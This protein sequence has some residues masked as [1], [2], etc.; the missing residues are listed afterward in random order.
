MRAVRCLSNVNLSGRAVLDL[1][2]TFETKIRITLNQHFP[3]HR[4]MRGMAYGASFTEGFMLENKRPRLF[5]MTLRAI[6]VETGHCQ[7]ACRFENVRTVWIMT[8]HAI[9]PP[10][11][12]G[13]VLGQIE[14]GMRLQ[15]AIETRRRVLSRID[16]ELASSPAHCNM[17]AA[18]S[19][20]G[21][22]PGSIRKF[23]VVKIQT[24]V[25]TSRK[26]ARD[27]GVAI[28]AGCISHISGAGHLNWHE[29]RLS[30]GRAGNDQRAHENDAGKDSDQGQ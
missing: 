28:I 12:Y 30:Q 29:N 9:H 6:L 22:A 10:L 3:I 19:V 26:V 13:M 27:I 1:S 23:G 7:S 8:L 21:F 17:L 14:F 25:S 16:D 4:A 2:V 20:A 11:G 24:S 5:P 18:W 15:M